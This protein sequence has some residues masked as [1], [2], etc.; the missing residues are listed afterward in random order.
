M[1]PSHRLWG[2]NHRTTHAWP[3][4]CPRPSNL[5]CSSTKSKQKQKN[6]KEGSQQRQV[7]VTI[8]PARHEQ[9]ACAA[10]P[11]YTTVATYYFAEV[12]SM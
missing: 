7:T 1:S 10:Y 9:G 12:C 4:E 6:G 11:G 5:P 3:L 8:Y 2:V